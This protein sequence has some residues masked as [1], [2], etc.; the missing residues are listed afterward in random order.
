M[1]NIDYNQTEQLNSLLGS[2]TT[3][4]CKMMM[5]KGFLKTCFRPWS[6]KCLSAFAHA[7]FYLCLSYSFHVEKNFRNC[8]MW[9]VWTSWAD[10]WF[11]LCASI[12]TVRIL[13]FSFFSDSPLLV[14]WSDIAYLSVRLYTSFLLLLSF[15]TWL[16]ECL[17]LNNSNTLLEDYDDSLVTCARWPYE[18]IQKG[19]FLDVCWSSWME[20][21]LPFPFWK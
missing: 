3:I 13:I 8:R 14:Y 16:M 4:L 19:H 18:Y 7:I 15:F 1:C 5:A 2:L 11:D 21:R 9:C 10:M 12:I 6:I 17:N 20:I